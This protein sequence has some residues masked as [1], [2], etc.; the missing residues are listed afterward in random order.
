M[1]L[2]LGRIGSRLLDL[3]NLTDRDGFISN[4]VISKNDLVERLDT[5]NELKW[6]D[7][8]NRIKLVIRSALLSAIS[9]DFKPP[10]SIMHY[11]Q[12][13]LIK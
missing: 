12:S 3:N 5:S 4:G 13:R 10:A 1:R 7:V 9:K 8:R 11:A 6:D 2:R